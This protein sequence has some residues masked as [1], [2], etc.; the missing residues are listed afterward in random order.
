MRDGRLQVIR[1]HDLEHPA[2]KLEGAH[3]RTDPA[4]QILPRCGLGEGV[5]A[6]AQQTSFSCRP[7]RTGGHPPVRKGGAMSG[8]PSV[9]ESR[10]LRGAYISTSTSSRCASMLY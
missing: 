8:M 6:G 5:A 3:M 7:A 1:H 10:G 2:E 9:S 4:P